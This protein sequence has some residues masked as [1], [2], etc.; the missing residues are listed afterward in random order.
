MRYLSLLLVL[1][2]LSVDAR[3][4]VRARAALWLVRLAARLDVQVVVMASSAI[5]ALAE[6]SAAE[7]TKESGK[8]F[9]P[10]LN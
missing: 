7:A 9:A 3:A 8:E 1:P 2:L 10:R 5:V 6:L 4:H